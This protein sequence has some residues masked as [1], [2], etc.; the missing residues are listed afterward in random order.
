MDLENAV[1]TNI[2]VTESSFM[3]ESMF[4]GFDG[5]I[6]TSFDSKDSFEENSI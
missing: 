4:D 3:E 5:R 1:V 6:V 2:D